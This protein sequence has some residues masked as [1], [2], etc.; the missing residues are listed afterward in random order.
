M[1]KDDDT[2]LEKT[3]GS[4]D[5]QDPCRV[6]PMRW[7]MPDPIDVFYVSFSSWFWNK[8]LSVANSTKLLV[9]ASNISQDIVVCVQ[10]YTSLPVCCRT[11]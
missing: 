11:Q 6:V 8:S 2:I 9:L 3:P 4:R 1:N 10:Q 7:P 5:S